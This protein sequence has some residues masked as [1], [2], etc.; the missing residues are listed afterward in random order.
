MRGAY[1]TALFC[2]SPSFFVHP[3]DKLQKRAILRMKVKDSQYLLTFK[4]TL[5]IPLKE[6]GV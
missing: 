4:E 3:I 1:C 5:L 2:M 6:G